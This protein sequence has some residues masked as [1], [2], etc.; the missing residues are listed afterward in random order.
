MDIFTAA[1]A[2]NLLIGIIG[3]TIA[4]PVDRGLQKVVR[5][6]GDQLEQGGEPANHDLQRALQRA[7][8]EATLLVCKACL[9]KKFGLEPEMASRYASRSEEVRL[10]D[11]IY[12][13]L[14]SKFGEV[15]GP[16]YTM[17]E[18][19]PQI[20]VKLLIARSESVRLEEIQTG[21]Q[22][23]VI[24]KLREW[25]SDL[26]ET[27]LKMIRE[28]Y[29]FD[30][31]CLCFAE[32]LKS[33][34][35][36]RAIFQSEILAENNAMLISL[37]K[38]VDV[39]LATLLPGKPRELPPPGITLPEDRTKL[40]PVCEWLPGRHR[41]PYRSLYR[42]FINKVREMWQLYDILLESGT[43]VVEGAGR[44]GLVVGMG[45]LGKT[46]F[47]IEY[48][49]RF[50]MC[51][52]AG[53]FWI[54]ADQGLSAM[55][56]QILQAAPDIEIDTRLS[57]KEQLGQLW[58]IFVQSEYP[59]LIVLDNFP[60]KESLRGWLPPSGPVHTLVTTRRRDLDYTRVPLEV[61]S[62]EEGIELLNASGRRT[63]GDEAGI[64][65]ETLAGL[66][67]AIELARKF[68]DAN[69]ISVDALLKEIKKMGEIGALN[70]FTKKYQDD[71]PSHHEKDV[72]ATIQ[73]SWDIASPGTKS[74]LQAMS[75]LAPSP[76][77]R[78]LLRKILGISSDESLL[79]D[80]LND[81]IS[82]ADRLSLAD[83]DEEN[84]PRMHRLIA[85][86]V[87]L[88]IGEDDEVYEKVAEAVME[89]M[90]RVTDDRDTPSLYELQKIVPHAERLLDL[91]FMTAEQATDI[92]TCIGWHYKDRGMY[93]L[94]ERFGKKAL[95]IAQA[96]YEPG[97][98]TI[99]RCQSN[100]AMV[101]QALGKSEEAE[102]LLRLAL[103]SWGKNLEAGHPLIATA[104]S[105]LAVVLQDLGKLEE[106]ET[107]LRL[108]LESDTNTF[109]PGHPSIARCQ[110]NLA[111]V[112]KALGKSEEA[113]TLLRLA[114]ESDTNTFE[115]GHPSIAR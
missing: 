96:N 85:G 101:L 79:E 35:R 5:S 12:K 26:P 32:M 53:I 98:P 95:E 8:L 104:Q 21:L 54:D 65:V 17:D 3:S 76:V 84:D 59:L 41:M 107:L 112:L 73:L 42:G 47:A 20:D 105:N 86:F 97:H 29:W 99:A 6:V 87:R 30:L 74:L 113:E 15:C 49:H 44:V 114:L 68:M 4:S 43:A 23:G 24:E 90:R 9:M 108:A 2:V 70:I 57:E 111:L 71:L 63:F 10:L 91:E 88:T 45:G 38:K 56:V 18:S 16:E 102:T 94:G 34:E 28:K 83:L 72:A 55:I 100:L 37:Q 48:V 61:M 31:V 67:L 62:P 81:G 64:L 92:S 69:P 52:P 103:E 36:V 77:P 27:L 109:G 46:Q 19:G 80:P 50:A 40:P 14:E 115:P 33:D 13:I 1:N 78:R 58:R 93:R 60:E 82:E 106:A 7:Y 75:L 66:P 51:Y 89:E 22:E 110:S 39:L 25:Q 11:G